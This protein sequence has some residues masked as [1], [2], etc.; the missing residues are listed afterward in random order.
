VTGEAIPEPAKSIQMKADAAALQEEYPEDEET[1][2]F[3]GE[4]R[5]PV[6]AQQ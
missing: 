4:E 6:P 1:E 3:E 2:E 5:L